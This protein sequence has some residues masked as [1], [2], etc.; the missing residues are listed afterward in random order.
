MHVYGR[1]L[2]DLRQNPGT[3]EDFV[4]AE[5]DLFDQKKEGEYDLGDSLPLAVY[6]PALLPNICAGEAHLTGFQL[7]IFFLRE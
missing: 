6:E 1:F 7:S 4:E 2:E 3:G 5:T